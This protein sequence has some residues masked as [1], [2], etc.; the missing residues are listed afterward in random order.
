MDNPRVDRQIAAGICDARSLVPG[1]PGNPA[2]A[3]LV[4][5]AVQYPD[6]QGTL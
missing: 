6:A 3:D 1:N 2:R 5:K 4:G